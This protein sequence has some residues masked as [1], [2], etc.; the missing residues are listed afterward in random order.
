MHELSL[1]RAIV[2][3]VSIAADENSIRHID[4]IEL[5]M[6]TLCGVLSESLSLAFEIAATDTPAEGALLCFSRS[7]VTLWCRQCEMVV[8]PENRLVFAC[9]ICLA[10]C[11][12]LLSGRE[13]EITRFTAR[14]EHEE[15]IV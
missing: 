6:G 12:E 14:R 13:F 15:V 10:P 5:K 9:P 8:T 2:S 11:P 4:T 1:A 7:E 3:E